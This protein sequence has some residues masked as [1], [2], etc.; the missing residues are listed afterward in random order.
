MDLSTISIAALT[1]AIVLSCTTRINVGLL[2]IVLAWLIGTYAAHLPLAQIVAGFPSQLFLT[3]VGVTLLF[4]QAQLNGTLDKV[5]H[6]AVGLCRGQVGTIPMMFFLLAMALAFIGPG[7]IASA[8]LIAPM[9]MAVAGRL[10]IAPFLM[11]IMVANGSSAASLSPFGPTG[12]VVNDLMIKMGLADVQWKNFL[13]VAVAHTAVGFGGYFL[14]GGWRYYRPGYAAPMAPFRAVGATL[15]RTVVGEDEGAVARADS[16]LALV[17]RPFEWRHW[18]T[19]A[20]IGVLLASVI[21]FEVNVGMAALAGAM[22]LILLRAGDE[23]GALKAMPWGPI[24]MVSG[25]TVLVALVE[26]TGG[27]ALFSSALAQVSDGQ[28]VH[29]YAALVTGVISI[30]SST[31]GVVLPA[32]LPTVPGIVERLG[33]GDLFALVSSMIIGAHLVDVSPLSTTGAL[34]IAAAPP[35]TD[36]RQMFRWMLAWG[37]SMSV[38]AAVGCYVVFGLLHVP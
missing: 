24:L 10:G 11:A 6:R 22:L 18:L 4:T 31:A 15:S 2:A 16:D 38:V 30:Y 5:A 14:F 23:S 25:V 34:C 36:T 1:A 19:L 7:S 12:L 13:T 8:A 17:A 35:G 26:K 28:T 33:T 3:L 9:A 32:F 20:V 21:A 29:G 27:I 37:V